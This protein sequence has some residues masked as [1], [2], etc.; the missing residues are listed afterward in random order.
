MIV[1]FR[2]SKTAYKIRKFPQKPMQNR[3]KK[4]AKLSLD[5][6][7]GMTG[8]EPAT[9]RPPDV[10]STKLSY[11]PLLKSPAL[12]NR[13]HY[14]RRRPTLPHFRCST[15]GAGGFNFSVRNG[16]RWYPPLSS[17][18]FL[19]TCID[20]DRKERRRIS[21][22]AQ[23]KSAVRKS[24][25]PLVPLGFAVTGFTPAAYPR[26]RLRRPSWEVSSSGEF[27]T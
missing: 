10:Y 1:D 20:S 2:Q 16:K 17:P 12:S 5:S 13:A 26:R 4:R 25:G 19:K 21:A 22:A 11:I 3:Y 9:T 15:I 6:L 24:I 8:F 7:V 27:R 14:G 23:L 18:C